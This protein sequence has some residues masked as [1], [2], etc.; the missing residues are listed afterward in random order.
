[1]KNAFKKIA[2]AAASATLLGGLAG[3]AQAANWLQLQ[4]TE[5]PG[6]APRAKIWGFIQPEYQYTEDTAIKAGPWAG[7]KAV[8]NQMRP[9]LQSNSGFN[10]IRT[11]VGVRG[12]AMPLD[13]NVN[14]FFLAEFGHNGITYP[15]GGLGNARITD[16]S[17][18]LNHIPGARVRVGMFKYP[19]SEEGLQAI[20]VF[21]YINFTNMSNQLLLERFFANT[22]AGT[23]GP[24]G[25]CP[26]ASGATA[27]ANAPTGPVGA[28]RDMGIQ[29]FDWFNRGNWEHAYAAMIGN[30][31]GLSLNDNNS[32]TYYLYW[33]STLLFGGKGARRED[34]KTYAWYQ[35]GRRSISTATNGAGGSIQSFDRK[36]YGIGTAFRRGKHRF[37]A[38][39]TKADGMIFNGTDGAALPGSTS[40]NTLFIASWNMAPEGEADG[41]YVHYGF[42]P[43][44]AWEF[45]IRYDILNRLTDSTAGERRFETW[46][47]GAQYFFNKKTRLIVNYEFR[48]AEAPNLDRS[49]TPNTILETIDN[50][51]STQI[52]TIF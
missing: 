3:P 19:G 44:Q 40:N 24:N 13:S 4:G 48:T 41:W 7:Q 46:T 33:S 28:F 42:A 47:L 20:H 36:R 9:N 5:R 6:A 16:A 43:T 27:C 51:V 50:R 2:L 14:Y 32:Y 52:L 49:A 10:V 17:V 35:D 21:D 8:F 45:D 30:G 37:A 11:R 22:G 12:T 29:V 23:A 18:T 26:A 31:N 15:A 38:E 25:F 34:W 1:M 39:Y